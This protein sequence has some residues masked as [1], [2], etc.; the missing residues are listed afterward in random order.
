MN[1]RE[2]VSKAIDKGNFATLE[3]YIDFTQR[4]LDFTAQ[5]LQA[6]IVSQNENHYQFY[7]YD[8]QGNYQ[9]TR[10]INAHLMYKSE[11]FSVDS[12]KFPEMLLHLKEIKPEPE[13]QIINKITY[14][15]QQSIGAALDGIE[16]GK[17][18]K[19]RKINGDLFENLIRLILNKM[20]IEAKAGVVQLPVVVSEREQFN[21]S[22]QHDLFDNNKRG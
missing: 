17:S 21:M 5:H 12:P 2:I 8:E 9:I 19:A 1:I 11:A 16:V 4:Y 6:V 7:Q 20:G 3:G 10:P 13:R 14:T 18:N 15:L 22:Y